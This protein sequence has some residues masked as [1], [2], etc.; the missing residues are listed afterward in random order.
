MN[1]ISIITMLVLS[2][3][4][5][6]ISIFPENASVS[7]PVQLPFSGVHMGLAIIIILVLWTVYRIYLRDN[8]KKIPKE[9]KKKDTSSKKY[10]VQEYQP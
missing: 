1:R 8:G 2:S 9:K 4:G 6:C 3:L 10:A 7:D 5:F